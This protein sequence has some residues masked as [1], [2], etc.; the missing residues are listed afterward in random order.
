MLVTAST[1]PQ[2]N[3]NHNVF[4]RSPVTGQFNNKKFLAF[5]CLI[6]LLLRFFFTWNFDFHQIINLVLLQLVFT[7]PF[8]CV[9]SLTVGHIRGMHVFAFRMLRQGALLNA[10]I[11]VRPCIISFTHQNIAHNS[12]KDKEVKEVK[13][14]VRMSVFIWKVSRKKRAQHNT[15]KKKKK[16]KNKKK[17]DD[18]DDHRFG[19]PRTYTWFMQ[20]TYMF[21]LSLLRHRVEFA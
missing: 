18:D 12:E 3:V 8:I 1:T 4:C 2:Q 16:K 10:H 15:Q 17:S 20:L 21:S 19:Q 9:A 6:S 7:F 13:K 14:L 5:C 11:D